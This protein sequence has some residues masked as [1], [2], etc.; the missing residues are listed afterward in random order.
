MSD[1]D[2]PGAIQAVQSL[3]QPLAEGEFSEKLYKVSVYLVSI[4]KSWDACLSGLE[5]LGSKEEEDPETYRKSA[6]AMINGF[7]TSLK[8]SISFARL[9]LDAALVQALEILVWRPK[10]ATKTDEQKKIQALQRT[11]DRQENPA[12]AMLEH[13]KTSSDPLNK[14]LVAGPWGHEY[15]GRRGADLEAYDHELSRMLSWGD[16]AEEKMVLGYCPLRRAIDA[17][18]ES[19]L[20]ELVKP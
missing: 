17:L 9:N 13:Y 4:Q 15:L 12:Q 10:N 1:A 8:N 3:L 14:Y 6:D 5:A 19:A 16:S 18:E 2:L 7:Q 11:F 20:K